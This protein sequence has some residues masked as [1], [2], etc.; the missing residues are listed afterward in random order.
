MTS[1]KIYDII[2]VGSGSVG[3]AASY[4]AAKAGLKVLM[5]DSNEPPHVNASHHGATRL[6]R[7]AYGQGE[8]Y[9]PMI[10]RARTLWDELVAITT[11]DII[12]P[13]GVINIGPQDSEFMNNCIKSAEKFKL[14]TEVMTPKE[15]CDRWPGIKVPADNLCI[16]ERDAGYLRP[17]L[18]IENLIRLSK[19]LGVEQLFNC[20]VTSIR[21]D[22]GIV[23]V[24]TN[25]GLFK[26][27]KAAVTTGT[28]VKELIPNLPIQPLRKVVAWH[29]ADERYNGNFPGFVIQIGDDNYYGFPKDSIGL[30]VGKH[31]GGQVVSRQDEVTPF[32]SCKEDEIERNE[33]LEKFLPGVG[34]VVEGVSCSYDMSPD[35]DFIIDILPNSMNILLITGLSGHG[36]KFSTV[37]GEIVALYAQNKTPQFDITPFALKRFAAMN[38]F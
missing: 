25:N 5:I 37:L 3:S 21:D 4:Y 26:G 32:G 15:V 33:L 36:Y 14:N 28:R 12:T 11:E 35:D 19:E 7:H 29:E 9:I 6:I 1:N 23:E 8:K 17:E 13:C 34:R 22:E 38:L 2:I 10:L 16:Y 31:N 30:K 18:A 27:V 20:K 24:N